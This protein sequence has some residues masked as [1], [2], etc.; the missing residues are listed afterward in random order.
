[1]RCFINWHAVQKEVRVESEEL[2]VDS[3]K[4]RVENGMFE[5]GE[6]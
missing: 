1:M 3:G 4:W 6:C 2:K 5:S